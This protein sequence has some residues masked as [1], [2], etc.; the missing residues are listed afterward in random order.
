MGR[1][2]NPRS[3]LSWSLLIIVV[4][5][6]A[7]TADWVN[8]AAGGEVMGF[9]SFIPPFASNPNISELLVGVNYALASAGI[10]VKSGKQGRMYKLGARKV[11]LVGVSS[12]GCTPGAIALV[13][14]T[15]GSLCA[16]SMNQLVTPFNDRLGSLIDQFNVNFPDAKFVYLNSTFANQLAIQATVAFA[17]VGV[18]QS[19]EVLCYFI[20]GDSIF[21]S[22]NNNNLA[23]SMKANYLPYGTDF[24]TGPTGRFTNGQ[25][26]ADIL[27]KLLGFDSFIPSFASKP[28][29]SELFVGCLYNLGAR[30]VA[31]AGVLPT[32]CTPS[33]IATA[34]G[35]NGSLY[36]DSLNQ[37]VA[38]FN[39]RIRLLVDR[40]NVDFP[41]AKFV[42]LDSTS[43]FNLAS[44]AL[45]IKTSPCRQARSTDGLCIPNSIPYPVSV[46]QS[47]LFWDALHPTEAANRVV[48]PA[49]YQTIKPIL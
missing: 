27:G 34:G 44:Q 49:F 35:T 47:Y 32:G 16:E 38:P 22:G 29:R 6:V 42:Y 5:M 12:V 28:N 11:G 17:A 10:L 43:A 24:P 18:S 19:P 4:V 3:P 33:A 26:T 15:N 25:T 45:G 9:E 14:R 23:T 41:D 37:L 1:P 30:K 13:G 8:S 21:D 2:W 40:L 48:A 46:R 31:L 39:S 7:T 20:F 36:V